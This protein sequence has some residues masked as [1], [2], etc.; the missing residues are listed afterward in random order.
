MNDVCKSIPEILN[1]EVHGYHRACYSKFIKN[2][3]LF[4]L[5]LVNHQMGPVNHLE[6]SSSDKI[7][8]AKDCIFCNKEGHKWHRKKGKGSV[9]EKTTVFDMGGG[10]TVQ[11]QAERKHGEKLLIGI[12][13]KCLFSVENKLF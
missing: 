2:I 1:E 4:S 6:R 9:S 10:K 5:T 12:R 13:G 7:L 11:E 3:D 8:I